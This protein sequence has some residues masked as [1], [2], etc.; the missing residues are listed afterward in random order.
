MSIQALDKACELMGGQ[1][2]LAD[3]LGIKS[4][5]ISEWRKRKR[6]PAE[7]CRAIERLTDGRVPCHELRPDL[8]AEPLAV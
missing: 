1:G 4:P 6:V 2:E 5:S 3:Q 7:R 8:F